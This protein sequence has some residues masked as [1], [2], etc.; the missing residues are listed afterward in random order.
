MVSDFWVHLSSSSFIC[1]HFLSLSS[2]HICTCFASWERGPDGAIS[3]AFYFFFKPLFF[4]SFSLWFNCAYSFQRRQK[5]SFTI[6]FSSC[7][8]V[9]FFYTFL[10]FFIVCDSC[11]VWLVR[12]PVGF[13]IV[14]TYGFI[15]R[16]LETK[17]GCDL[18]TPYIENNFNS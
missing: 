8:F 10:Y 17:D 9:L 7:L 11:V 5:L 16:H 1:L 13:F 18:C 4:F 15:K 6:L 12:L 3:N 14:G 2:S